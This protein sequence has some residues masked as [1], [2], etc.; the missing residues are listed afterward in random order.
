MPTIWL[1]RVAGAREATRRLILLAAAE[2][3]GEAALLWRAAERLSIDPNAL[4]PAS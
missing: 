3:L 2:P 4:A 1:R